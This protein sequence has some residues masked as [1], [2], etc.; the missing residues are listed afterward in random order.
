MT[1]ARKTIS[2]QD[3]KLSKAA[4]QLEI[5]QEQATDISAQYD[6]DINNIREHCE[7][8]LRYIFW[9]VHLSYEDMKYVMYLFALIF[10][11]NYKEPLPPRI[12]P[13]LTEFSL[14]VARKWEKFTAPA[15]PDDKNK[16]V[17]V[18]A[19]VRPRTDEE[20]ASEDKR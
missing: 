18:K 13:P 15:N 5:A 11:K 9:K 17:W 1:D 3:V 7:D 6:V 2:Q 4:K 16:N 12:L 20:M 10:G 19:R 14:Q 8:V